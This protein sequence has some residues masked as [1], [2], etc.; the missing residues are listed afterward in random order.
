MFLPLCQFA[1]RFEALLLTMM[2]GRLHSC[3]ERLEKIGVYHY[4]YF[5]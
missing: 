5:I 3:P 4:Q 1:R 2:A